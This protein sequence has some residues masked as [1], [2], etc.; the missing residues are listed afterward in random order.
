MSLLFKEKETVRC[1]LI[2][3]FLGQVAM[4]LAFYPTW[5][6]WEPLLLFFFVAMSVLS[7][8]FLSYSTFSFGIGYRESLG[9]L[10]FQGISIR[11]VSLMF[12]LSTY[13]CLYAVYFINQPFNQ[14]LLFGL[15]VLAALVLRALLVDEYKSGETTIRILSEK[16]YLSITVILVACLVLARTLG[17][18]LDSTVA[19]VVYTS[20]FVVLIGWLSFGY[21]LIKTHSKDWVQRGTEE[22]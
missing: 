3:V 16:H 5:Y 19:Y 17:L 10:H 7:I 13:S 1:S 12:L 8:W 18:L 11:Y 20:L 21:Y 2:S 4:I 15:L 9:P 22:S 6:M 14:L